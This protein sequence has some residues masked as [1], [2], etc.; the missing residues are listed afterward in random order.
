MLQNLIAASLAVFGA[1][2]ISTILI[3]LLAQV[4]TRMELWLCTPPFG[5]KTVISLAGVS[6]WLLVTMGLSVLPWSF[7]FLWIGAFPNLETAVYF[8]SVTYTTLGYG[9]VVLPLESRGLSGLC[10]ANGLLM[11]GLFTAFLVEFLRRL[12]QAH[13][14]A[15][16]N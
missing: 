13:Q 16:R 3:G 15:E 11:F 1:I 9:D 14:S 6:A 4:L 2:A 5:V 8:T 12:R 7:A 10:A